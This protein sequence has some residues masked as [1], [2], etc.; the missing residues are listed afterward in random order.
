MLIEERPEE[1]SKAGEQTQDSV[2]TEI[3]EKR[4]PNV[5]DWCTY[6]DYVK[7][8]D[9]NADCPE[10]MI[11]ADQKKADWDSFVKRL[12]TETVHEAEN[13]GVRNR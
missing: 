9:L 8:C 3:E 6:E 11:P 10:E 1:Q 7:Y 2:A 4:D 5:T 13:Y 12:A